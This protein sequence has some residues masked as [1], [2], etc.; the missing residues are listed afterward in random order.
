MNK[1]IVTAFNESYIKLGATLIASII[2]H[3]NNVDIIVLDTGIS[4]FSKY[5]LSSWAKTKGVEI[6]FIKITN[7]LFSKHFGHDIHVPEQYE[8]YA[9]LLVPYLLPPKIDVIL[10]L[11]ADI[12]CLSDFSEIFQINIGENVIAAR[13][14][15][16]YKKFNSIMFSRGTSIIPNYKELGISGENSYFNSGVMLIDV[17]KWKSELVSNKVLDLTFNNTKHLILWDQ[18]GLNISLVKKWFN[19]DEK[20]NVMQCPKE[21]DTVVFRHFAKYKPTNYNYPYLDKKTFFEYLDLSPWKNWRPNNSIFTYTKIK[22]FL[23]RFL[24]KYRKFFKNKS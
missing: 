24:K 14:D 22:H 8:Y 11:D 4:L 10:Y 1:T 21:N 23:T 15:I 5:K 13:E 2:E 9:R 6:E 12:I 16:G 17:Q 3:N 18:Y 20:W 7:K 19:L